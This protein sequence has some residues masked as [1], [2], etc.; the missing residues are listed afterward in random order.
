MGIG[1]G[2]GGVGG[3]L[4]G[5]RCQLFGIFP[6]D[7]G[8]DVGNHEF[9]LLQLGFQ[10]V[11]DDG[12][13]EG[14]FGHPGVG[15]AGYEFAEG[16]EGDDEGGKDHE[17]DHAESQYDKEVDAGE[18]EGDFFLVGLAVHDNEAMFVFDDVADDIFLVPD[19]VEDGLDFGCHCG[20]EMAGVAIY[21]VIMSFF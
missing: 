14:L 7:D 5:G 15:V 6:C 12:I 8:F 20:E 21:C 2:C 11:D 13:L 1:F 3:V 10:G 4:L 19:G 16:G 18:L 17:D 9:L